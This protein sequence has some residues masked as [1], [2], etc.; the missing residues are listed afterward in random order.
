VAIYTES[1]VTLAS[2]KNNTKHSFLIEENR[3]KVRNLKKQIWSI[4]FGWVKAHTGM[5]GNEVEDTFVK[6]AS[7][8]DEDRNIV[9]DRI[10]ISAI[11]NRVKE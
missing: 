4:R 9:Y 7:Q 1:K 2:L 6:E 8:D 3:N 11:A 10:S 5:E